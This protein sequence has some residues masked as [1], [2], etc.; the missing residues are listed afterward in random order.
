[1]QGHYIGTS[2]YSYPYWKGR[3]Y[4][5]GL[6]ASQQLNYYSKQFNTVEL[7]YTFYRFPSVKALKMAAATVPDGFLFSL[8]MHRSITH[9]LRMQQVK[10]KIHEFMDIVH[11]GLGDRLGC[12]LFQF[13]ASY[14]FNE[15]RLN[16]ILDNVPH[17]NNNV[18]E[19]RHISWWQENVYQAL[20]AAYLTFC[21]VSFPGLPDDN[22]ITGNVFYKRMHGV[23]QLFISA[24][25]D[26]SILNLAGAI[27][28][29]KTS[30]IYFN[31][32]MYEAGYSN[33]LLLDQYLKKTL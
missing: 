16:D 1:M 33:A 3:F 18:I 24:Y 15:Q 9:L 2:G 12:V 13:P 26:D 19:F 5:E 31:N 8:K 25:S 29:D 23:P 4:P 21:S 6:P 14:Q 30:F 32:T 10:A 27:P 20:R 11:E 22:I 28:E 17:H 7:N